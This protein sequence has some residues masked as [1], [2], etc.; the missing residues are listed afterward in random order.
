MLISFQV[1]EQFYTTFYGYEDDGILDVNNRN[2]K[3]ALKLVFLD[4]INKNLE[5]FQIGWNNHKIRTANHRTPNQ[6]WLGGMLANQNSNH[7]AVKDI[8]SDT[9][10]MEEKIH[11]YLQQNPQL[12]D[13]GAVISGAGNDEEHLSPQQME[14]LN[15]LLSQ[16]SSNKEEYTACVSWLNT[17]LNTSP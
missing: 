5:L 15:E 11:Q 17:F 4:K 16:Y 14:E 13:V 2:H 9:D 10:V 8:F 1:I 3:L 12:N 6:L 7:T